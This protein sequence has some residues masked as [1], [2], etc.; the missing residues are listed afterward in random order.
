MERREYII[1]LLILSSYGFFKE[2]RPSEPYL[3]EYLIDPQYDIGLNKT[4]LYTKVT[5]TKFLLWFYTKV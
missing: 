3:T 4:D 2:I 5:Y 1:T